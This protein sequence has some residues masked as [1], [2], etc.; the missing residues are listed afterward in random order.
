MLGRDR[1]GS[2]FTPIPGCDT[3][4]A[5]KPDVQNLASRVPWD[6]LPPTGPTFTTIGNNAFS[7]EAWIS[8]LTPGGAFQ[9]FGVPPVTSGVRD[10]SFPWTNQWEAQDC[11]PATTFPSA[12]RN[13]IDAAVTNLFAMHNRLH[14]WDYFLGFTEENWNAQFHNLRSRIGARP[15]PGR[16]PGWWADRRVA[17][18]P[19]S[20][21]RQH[22]HDA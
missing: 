16:R 18:L 5:G 3:V 10:Y 9:P 8:P 19:R 4:A 12:Q 14:D 6:V 13:D 20:R 17:E 15:G 21:Q 1:S 11:D 7:R 2:T 22:G